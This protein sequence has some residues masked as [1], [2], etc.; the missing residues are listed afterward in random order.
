MWEATINLFGSNSFPKWV[1]DW[2]ICIAGCM[3]SAVCC[4]AAVTKF[5]LTFC[6]VYPSTPTDTSWVKGLLEPVPATLGDGGTGYTSSLQGILFVK[7]ETGWIKWLQKAWHS[8]SKTSELNY[9]NST[10][11]YHINIVLCIFK[12]EKVLHTFLHYLW[13]FDSR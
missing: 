13:I 5:F 4:T 3:T 6:C 7:V 1:I 9:F 2:L 8:G 10:T 12:S 11:L